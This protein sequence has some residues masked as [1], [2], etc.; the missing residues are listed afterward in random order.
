[1]ARDQGQK[2]TLWNYI[3]HSVHTDSYF[4]CGNVNV[5]SCLYSTAADGG[6]GY[7]TINRGLVSCPNLAVVF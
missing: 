3:Q 4:R 1:M 2:L 7:E 6:S 5:N